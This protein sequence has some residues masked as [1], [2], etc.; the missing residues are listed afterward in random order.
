M[1][2]VT[3]LSGLG[4]NFIVPTA[5]FVPSSADDWE[6]EIAA[7]T[8]GSGSVT[9]GDSDDSIR[10]KTITFPS[11]FTLTIVINDTANNWCWGAYDVAEDSTFLGTDSAGTGDMNLMT[12]SWFIQGLASSAA[13]GYYGSA[14]EDS[15]WT[16]SAGNTHTFKRVGSLF[17]WA[18]AGVEKVSWANTATTTVRF[19]GGNANQRGDC[20]GLTVT[21]NTQ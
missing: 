19:V 9:W 11:D 18:D 3:A 20:T 14:T 10:L 16:T 17:T 4:G 8:F 7:T 12:N 13:Q 21:Y 15:G 1:L 6:G 2:T 5:T